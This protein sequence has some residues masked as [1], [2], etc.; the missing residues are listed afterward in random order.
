MAD[1][2]T[3]LL[4]HFR[5]PEEHTM[6][7]QPKQAAAPLT[8]AQAAHAQALEKTL[9][10]S[11]APG[12][13][14]RAFAEGLARKGLCVTDNGEIGLV[15]TPQPVVARAM[16]RA[17]LAAKGL[18]TSED[19]VLRTVAEHAQYRAGREA[20]RDA[21]SDERFATI[22]NGANA[23]STAKYRPLLEMNDERF[24]DL[25]FGANRGKHR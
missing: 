5:E 12:G 24:A 19:G 20:D 16:F 6:P 22:L 11:P 13:G 17:A 15:P 2:P 25:M 14:V 3:R 1:Q 21:A 10:G 4:I 8:N 23:A 18:M 7:Q 9:T